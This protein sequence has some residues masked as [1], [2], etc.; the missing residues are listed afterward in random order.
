[1]GM[2]GVELVMAFE[3]AFGI[4]IPD[5]AASEMITPRDT[6]KYIVLRLS[7]TPTA[8][9]LTQ[10][11]FYRVRRGLRLELRSSHDLRPSTVLS[12]LASTRE[13]LGL[14]SRIRTS[15]GEPSWP[16]IVPR[17]GWFTQGPTTLRQ[18]TRFVAMNMPQARHIA[19]ESWTREQIEWTLRNTVREC[20][21]IETFELDDQYVR[22]M[23]ID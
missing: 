22:D 6:I 12:D 3:E 23:G 21:G 7:P 10:Q 2:D 14:W 20:Q 16:E 15:T 1:M 5:A 17:I 9:C 4:D 18:L 19:G 11:I 13:W 8:Y